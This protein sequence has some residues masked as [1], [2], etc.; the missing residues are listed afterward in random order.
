MACSGAPAKPQQHVAGVADNTADTDQDRR[1]RLIAELQD[2]ILSSYEREELP[3]ETTMI[4]AN[5]GQA[6]VGVGPGDVYYGEGFKR[7]PSRWPLRVD[8][9]T[10]HVVR[11][12]RLDIHLAQDKLVSAAW[13]SD[14][15][16]WRVTFCGRTAVLPLRITALY[17][18]DGDRWIEVFEHLSYA[19]LPAPSSDGKLVGAEIV[20][21]HPGKLYG[22]LLETLRPLLRHDLAHMKEVVSIDPEHLA[23]ADPKQAAPTLLLS[24]DPQGEWHGDAVGCTARGTQQATEGKPLPQECDLN[25]QLVDGM[26]INDDARIGTVGRNPETATI[27]YWVGNFVATL[28]ARP[29]AIGGRVRLRGTFIF[30]KR[31][32]LDA[33]G[34][35][36]G[37]TVWVVVQGHVS[38]PIQ[39]DELAQIVFGTALES[40]QLF[41]GEP[42]RV[43]CDDGRRTTRAPAGQ[44]TRSP[45][46]EV[47]P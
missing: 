30:E 23:E 15:V 38:E 25:V 31:K 13:M 3:D 1:L 14:E 11:S 20:S 41:K 9:T 10:P 29:N 44:T 28:D 16:S 34:Q 46:P 12:K 19:R 24:P 33:A 47:G 42:L 43:T 5:V 7:A 27:A 18:H 17:A 35:P 40:T 6:R 22:E 4:L 45:T 8:A 32:Q 39:D 37:K 2:D 36:T 21:A 26:L